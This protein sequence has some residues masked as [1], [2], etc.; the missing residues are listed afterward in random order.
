MNF[1]NI[2]NMHT[3]LNAYSLR[4]ESINNNLANV[5][6]P[7]YK[8]EV[9][10]F[11]EFLKDSRGKYINGYKTH[12]KH[13]DIPNIGSSKAPYVDKDRSFST[14][15][16]GNNVNADLEMADLV[17]NSVN[18]NAVTQQISN[19]FRGLKTAITGGNR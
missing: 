3:A 14:R 13:I 18:Y 5:N 7:N 8:R 10:R 2:R 16:D 19:R 9:V 11:E 4:N 6:T 1:N 17:K 15:I 12:E